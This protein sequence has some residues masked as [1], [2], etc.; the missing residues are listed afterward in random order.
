MRGPGIAH[1]VGCV[2]RRP[3]RS[4]L[5][6]AAVTAALATAPAASAQQAPPGP[7]SSHGCVPTDG[8]FLMQINGF[9]TNWPTNTEVTTTF[10]FA[11]G[12]VVTLD[13]NTGDDD[14]FHTATFT[15]DMRDPEFA[16]LV[17]TSVFQTAVGGGIE[18]S[19]S[20]TII[21]C[22]PTPADREACVDEGYLRYPSLGFLNQGD[23]VS[24]VATKGKN[25]PGQNLP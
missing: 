3:L 17:G 12:F 1:T 9:G 19:F 25:E 18:T 4:L 14:V 11:N 2:T 15:L 7:G 16:A 24:W 21:G 6:L 10:H 23:C 22:D 13:A 5:A 8:G 20:W